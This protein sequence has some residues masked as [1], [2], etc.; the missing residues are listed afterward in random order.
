MDQISQ[1]IKQLSPTN[2]NTPVLGKVRKFN[3]DTFGVPA[4][5][6]P[7]KTEQQRLVELVMA[8]GVQGKSDAGRKFGQALR[9]A[10]PAWA[11]NNLL[12]KIPSNVKGFYESPGNARRLLSGKPSINGSIPVEDMNFTQSLE[13]VRKLIRKG[14]N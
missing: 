5:A 10:V 11:E 4:Y 9:T 6:D 12:G 7:K 1:L 8:L 2:Y 13:N 3:A 14:S